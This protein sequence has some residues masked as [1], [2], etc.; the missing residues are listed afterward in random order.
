M[1]KRLQV[2][3]KARAHRAPSQAEAAVERRAEALH[4]ARIIYERRR[5]LRPP[6]RELLRTLFA[7]GADLELTNGEVLEAVEAYEDVRG[8]G[9]SVV[10]ANQEEE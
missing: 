7:Q 4:A 5:K 6:D 1:V 3:G 2:G 9:P 8:V 10:P